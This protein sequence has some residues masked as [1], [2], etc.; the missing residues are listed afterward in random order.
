M[1]PDQLDADSLP[2]YAILDAIVEHYVE[3]DRGVEEI[4]QMGFD[5]EDV[6]R[7]VRLIHINEYKRRQSPRGSCDGERVWEGLAIPDYE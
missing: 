5:K 4:I 7:I 6:E 3:F 1:R 2:D